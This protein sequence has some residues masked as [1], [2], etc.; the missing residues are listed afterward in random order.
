MKPQQDYTTIRP[1]DY[2]TTH[3]GAISS[4]HAWTRTSDQTRGEIIYVVD[5]IQREYEGQETPTFEPVESFFVEEERH[6]LR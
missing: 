6:Q 4:C 2:G 5:I 1:G 3:L